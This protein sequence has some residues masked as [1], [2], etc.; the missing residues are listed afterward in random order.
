MEQVGELVWERDPLGHSS[1]LEVRTRCAGSCAWMVL[2][3]GDAADG[4][5]N[6]GELV[7][8]TKLEKNLQ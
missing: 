2:A 1:L 7:P 8:F 6:E 5:T 3:K 4:R